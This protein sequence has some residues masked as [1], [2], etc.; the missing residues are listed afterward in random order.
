MYSASAEG[1]ALPSAAGADRSAAPAGAAPPDVPAPPQNG[2]LRAGSVDDNADF[3]RYLDYLARYTSLG[4][5]DR[6]FDPSG[7]IVV[8]VRGENGLPAMGVPVAVSSGGQA[9]ATLLT[10]ATGR[11]IF[12]PALYGNP[13]PAY[14][15]DAADGAADVTAGDPVSLTVASSQLPAAVPVD[16]LFLLDVTG[17]MGDEIDRL[18]QTIDQVAAQL[19][20]L[21]QHPD[22]R[23]G[24]T[25]YRDEGDT[26]VTRT[27]DF[28]GDVA[29]FRDALSDVVADGGGD[30]PEAV[31][32]AL[33]AALAEPSWRDPATTVQTIFLVG[34]AAPHTE[35]Q[36][37][38]PWTASVVE[39][40]RRGITIDSIAAS[41]TDDAAEHAFRGIAEATAGKFVFMSYGAA[42]A[43]VGTNTDITKA[44]YEEMSLDA[45]VVRFVSEQLAAL[46]GTAVEPP[47]T[48]P[49]T[50]P[51]NP[52]GQ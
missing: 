2:G 51:T 43:A 3:A 6:P 15:V 7:R 49:T 50:P 52:P 36:L 24:M 22:L 42:G 31:E 1:G 9:V 28:T 25:L 40:A 12:L 48:A 11:A 45:L 38:E 35:R 16:V 30:T 20:A 47:P 19:S 17:S 21:P 5:A 10:D 4:L 14:H 27:F 37:D 44:D 46:T 34:D 26:F 13:Q 32:E 8:T 29:A 39:A 18:K 33:S 23:L 41:N